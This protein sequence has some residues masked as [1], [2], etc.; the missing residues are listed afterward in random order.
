MAKHKYAKKRAATRRSPFNFK[1][2]AKSKSKGENVQNIIMAGA[3]YGAIRAPIALAADSLLA[4][5][6]LPAQIADEVAMGVA[7]YFMYKKGK[8][9]IKKIGKAGLYAEAYRAGDTFA[10][11]MVAGVI[12][13]FQSGTASTN[14]GGLYVN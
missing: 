2:K 13:Q 6:P 3:A 14:N 11:P 4:K 12:G 9:F 7:S 1:R 10:A 8:G 5:L